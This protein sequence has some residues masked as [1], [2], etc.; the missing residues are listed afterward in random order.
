VEA[1]T[2]SPN[3]NM[4]GGLHGLEASPDLSSCAESMEA[5]KD[6]AHFKIYKGIYCFATSEASM[7]SP[8]EWFHYLI[9]SFPLLDCVSK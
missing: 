7:D 5:S 3:F 4:D 8:N 1:F 9:F 2:D 6:L